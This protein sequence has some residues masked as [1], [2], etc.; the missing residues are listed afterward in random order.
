MLLKLSLLLKITS[1]LFENKEEADFQ[2]LNDLETEWNNF[3][4]SYQAPNCLRWNKKN[5][6]GRDCI[7]KTKPSLGWVLWVVFLQHQRKRRKKRLWAPW[8]FFSSL[9]VFTQPQVAAFQYNKLQWLQTQLNSNHLLSVLSAVLSCIFYCQS[10]CETV[11]KPVLLS[12]SPA[13]WF[14]SC[15]EGEHVLM[16]PLKSIRNGSLSSG[17]ALLEWFWS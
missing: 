8:E 6:G 1:V 14:S 2:D 15:G 13:E 12:R 11:L 4:S 17:N 16:S 5:G 3:A 7:L 9:G 10:S